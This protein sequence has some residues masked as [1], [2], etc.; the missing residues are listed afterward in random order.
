MQ[1]FKLLVR[2]SLLASTALLLSISS[3]N[4]ELNSADDP[5]FGTDSLTID[6]ETNLVWLDISQTNDRCFSQ[7]SDQFFVNG[8]FEG[9]RFATAEEVLAFFDHAGIPD[10]PPA[11]ANG[12]ARTV[13]NFARVVALLNLIGVT[14]STNNAVGITSTQVL[15]PDGFNRL[16]QARAIT[17]SAEGSVVLG[18]TSRSN[19][20]TCNSVGA[21]LVKPATAPSDVDGDGIPDIVD[22]CPADPDLTNPCNVTGSAA[23]EV[24]ADEGGIVSSEDGGIILVIDEYEVSEDVV[25]SVTESS[26]LEPDVVLSIGSGEPLA[27]YTFEPDGQM[28]NNFI[29]VTISFDV[30][31]LGSASRGVLDIY[32][33]EQ[34]ADGDGVLDTY[35]PLEA[36]CTIATVE[37]T[38]IATCS[39]EILHFTDYA[40]II[41][42]DSDNDG[43]FDNF[44]GSVD[45]CPNENATGFDVDDDGCIDSFSGL[46]DLLSGLVSE[47][48]IDT[49]M[50]NSLN[51]KVSNANESASKENI[52]DA[53]DQLGAFGNQVNAQRS[54]KIGSEGAGL[55][56]E[57]TESLSNYLYTLLAEGSNC[58]S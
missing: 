13:S 32:R 40:V 48:V 27:S 15:N 26:T 23:S 22:D 54:K 28:F 2:Y 10:L 3:A 37:L 8:D 12:Q 56:T 33:L 19:V 46:L 53:I 49:K 51:K 38:D 11:G 20:P 47:G 24:T 42:L 58:S 50:E 21:W 6:T 5:V 29:T 30:T 45:Y 57:Y 39:V 14:Q 41:P 7:V 17:T 43:V 55:V 25:I 1:S 18:Y 4:A 31:D 36:T 35:V 34:D 44:N 52:C 16:V 9:F